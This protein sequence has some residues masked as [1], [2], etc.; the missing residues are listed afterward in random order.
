MTDN[1][2][3]LFLN[4]TAG[5]GRAGRRIARIE[6]LFNSRNIPLSVI[7][8]RA[9]GDLEDKVTTHVN[10]GARK[11]IVA[12]GD[13]S[14]HEV[15]NGMLRADTASS[16]GIIPTG[17]GNDFAKAC[18]ITL[19]WE[20]ATRSLADRIVANDTPRKIDVGRMNDRYFANGAGIGFDAK[21]T[22]VARAF[23]WHIGDFIYLFA[24]LRCLYDGVATPEIL[25]NS[26][27]FS[28]RGP[29]TLASVSNGPWVGGIFHIA[30]MASNTDGHLDLLIVAPVSRLRVLALL[31]KL[32]RGRHMSEPEI[33]H[34]T[35]RS[36]TVSSELPLESHLDGEVQPLQ[37]EFEFSIL[38]QALDLL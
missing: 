25:I 2:I 7:T 12:G 31:P 20:Q 16:L 21:V 1:T 4:P 13:G 26:S 23:R 24:I 37:S 28:W 10:N 38:P 22:R 17:T 27:E 19:D 9:M 8:S 5:R 33:T 6:Q 32:M 3:P 14:V 15:V 18:G 30:P 34:V 29:L 36:I 11:I 35:A